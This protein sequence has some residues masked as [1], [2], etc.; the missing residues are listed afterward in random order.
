MRKFILAR[1][2][3]TPVELGAFVFV[4]LEP[5]K[6]DDQTELDLRAEP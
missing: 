5:L 3:W 4:V 6:L 1:V 2:R